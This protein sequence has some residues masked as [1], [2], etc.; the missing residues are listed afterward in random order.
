MI[1]PLFFDFL[2]RH[3][4]TEA[5]RFNRSLVAM[6]KHLQI[7]EFWDADLLYQ[8]YRPIETEAKTETETVKTE[9]ETGTETGTEKRF[10]KLINQHDSNQ[11]YINKAVAKVEGLSASMISAY[12]TGKRSPKNKD[13]WQRWETAQPRGW[14]ARELKT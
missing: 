10:K 3:L 9:T 14:I 12:R 13:F 11:V 1:S 2:D 6:A 8:G 7:E 5:A 4:D